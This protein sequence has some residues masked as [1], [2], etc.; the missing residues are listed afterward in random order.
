MI[1]VLDKDLGPEI[2]SF[3][4]YMCE[5]LPVCISIHH[6]HRWCPQRI[7]EGASPLRIGETEYCEA[8][9]GSGT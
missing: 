5:C 1:P 3:I 7:E 8:P 4:S 9:L 2:F 6:M